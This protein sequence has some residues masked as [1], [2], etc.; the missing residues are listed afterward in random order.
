MKTIEEILETVVKINEQ[1]RHGVMVAEYCRE[2][3]KD[4]TQEDHRI[5]HLKRA[6]AYLDDLPE[7]LTWKDK[8]ERVEKPLTVKTQHRI[9]LP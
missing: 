3:P 4:T 5:N 1:I 9:V 8:W 6:M 7:Y 2:C